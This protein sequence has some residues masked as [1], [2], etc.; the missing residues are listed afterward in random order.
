MNRITRMISLAA[1]CL[2][3]LAATGGAGVAPARPGAVDDAR[4]MAAASEP[5][6]WLVNGGTLNGDHYSSL[7]QI[8]LDTVKDLKPAWS[9]DFDTVR[10]QEAEPLVVDGVMYVSTSW[11]KVYALDAATGRKI[12]FFDPEVPGDTGVKVCCD[13]VNRG[14]AVYKGKV[15]VGTLDGRLIALDA[16]T[17]TPVWSTQTVD[18]KSALTIT[19]A[20][21]VIHDKVI[22]GNAGADFGVRGYVSAYDAA[23]GKMVWRFYTV[24]G[25]P[26]KGPDHAA[27]DSVME[28]LVRPTWAGDYAKYGGGG[29]V[30]QTIM[31]DQELNQLYIGTGNGSP[32]NPKYRTDGKGDN[33][34]LCSVIALDPDTGRYIWHYQENPQE[35]WDYNSVQPMILTDLTIDGKVR[36][37]LMHAPKNGFFYV[38]DRTNGKVIS[39]KP[40][41]PVTWASGI[42]LTTGRPIET[43]NSRYTEGPFL[44]KPNSSGAHNWHAMAYDPKTGLV[45]LNAFEN[46]SLLR[47]NPDFKPYQR[48]PFNTGLLSKLK[49]GPTYLLAWNPVTQTEAWRVRADR[50]GVLATAGGLVF[51]GQGGVTGRFSAFRADN[52]R[53]VWDYRMPNGVQAAPITYSVGGVQY[54]AITTGNGA[55]PAQ[56]DADERDRQPG[57]MVAF[58]LNGTATLPAEPGAPPP[59][60]PTTD[61][62]TAEQVAHGGVNYGIFCSRCHGPAAVSSNVIPDLRRSGFLASRDAWRAVVIDG[63][64]TGSGMVGWKQHLSEAQAEEIRGYVSAQAVKLQQR[65]PGMAT[66]TPSE[67]ASPEQ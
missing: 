67:S 9:F 10:G 59:P 28:T 34:F 65:G 27:S 23:T 1:V 8:N 56:G 5:Q 25:D 14:V 42:D 30:W 39:A 41:V 3:L 20:P 24:P 22:I 2:P 61:R 64:L 55:S 15:Y 31:Y 66:A 7:D 53:E 36:K 12:W 58:R 51:Q 57:R 32:W 6:N 33:L 29:T 44:L 48:G 49:S 63:A 16:R 62:F 38:L 52:G 60:N 21:R 54:I 19:G 43:P 18:P 13:T 4:M 45:Y 50:A 35:A 47:D 46:S 26:A 17:G 40:Y 11:S 37:V